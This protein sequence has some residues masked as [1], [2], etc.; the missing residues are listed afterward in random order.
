MKKAITFACVFIVIL[1]VISYFCQKN[2]INQP[3][4]NCPPTKGTGLSDGVR[5]KKETYSFRQAFLS[6]HNKERE[7][8]GYE[9]LAIDEN[10]CEYA[11][12]HAEAMAKEGRL[13]HSRMSELQKVNG[14][15]YVGEN[16]AWGHKNE[17]DVMT[18]WMWSP[19]HRWNILSSDYKKAGFGAAKDLDGKHYWCVVF[20]N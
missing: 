7:K 3:N 20:S 4:V 9:P 2:L 10:L 14:S 11:Q 8:W 17:T 18:A 15:E 12:R 1:F 16:I 5:I 19:M 6:V 13:N